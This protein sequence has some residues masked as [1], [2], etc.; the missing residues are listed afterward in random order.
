VLGGRERLNTAQGQAAT[1][2]CNQAKPTFILCP[3]PQRLGGPPQELQLCEREER[4]VPLDG[5][6]DQRGLVEAM[7]E[8]GAKLRFGVG[9]FL[10]CV[11]RATAKRAPKRCVAVY[12]ITR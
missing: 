11:R 5:R 8:R 2:H 4:A 1:L 10:T 12:Q 3:D 9:L 6:R 7:G